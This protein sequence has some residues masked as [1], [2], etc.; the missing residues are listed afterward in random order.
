MLESYLIPASPVT[1]EEEI[2]RSRFITLLSHCNNNA[3]FT[4]FY[5]QVKKQYPNANHYCSAFIF[6]TPLCD[7]AIGSSDDGEPAGSAGRPMLAVL[8]GANIGEIAAIVVRYFG[9]TK[10]GVG[11]LVRAYSSGVR[12]A[13]VELNTEIKLIRQ[14]VSLT[15]EYSQLKDLQHIIQKHNGL[16]VCCDYAENIQLNFELAN[17]SFASF[18]KDLA[19]LSNGSLK[20]VT[21]ENGIINKE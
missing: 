13:L 6:D 4:D 7:T 10:L 11:G 16:I 14:P 19:S 21:K 9:G 15:I 18:N 5:E 8:Q 12:K 2:K 17:S 1:F 20:I 3:D